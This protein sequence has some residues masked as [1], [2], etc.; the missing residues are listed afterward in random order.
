MPAPDLPTPVLRQ[1][2]LEQWHA[3]HETA[4]NGMWGLALA[5]DQRAW[6]EVVHT[7]RWVREAF[8]PQNL[9][10]EQ[11]MFPLLDQAGARTLRQALWGDHREMGRLAQGVLEAW[12]GGATDGPRARRLLDLVRQHID[13]EQHRA[14]PLLRGQKPLADAVPQGAGYHT[15]TRF[16]ARR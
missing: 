15:P 2:S 8:H 5:L 6:A 12:D 13:T 16:P 3:F 11:R 9:W 10:E 14:L 1:A 7:C 4:L